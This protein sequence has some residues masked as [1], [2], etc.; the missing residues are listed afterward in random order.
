M[1]GGTC[2]IERFH[3]LHLRTELTNWASLE[4]A[5]IGKLGLVLMLLLLLLVYA[6]FEKPLQPQNSLTINFSF[7]YFP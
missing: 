6:T 3:W 1:F 2:R 5:K 4:F 7:I